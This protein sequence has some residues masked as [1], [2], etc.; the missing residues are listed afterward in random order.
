MGQRLDNID[1]LTLEIRERNVKLGWR[2]GRNTFGDYAAL[3]H[4]EVSEMVEACRDYGTTDATGLIGGVRLLP[5]KPEGVG[6]EAADVAIRLIDWADVFDL[7]G[8]LTPTGTKAPL[9]RIPPVTFGD[10]CSLLHRRISGA[11]G[12]FHNIEDGMV[13]VALNT[14][15]GTLLDFCDNFGIDL[16]AEV[17]RK[18]A[19]NATRPYRHGRGMLADRTGLGELGGTGAR[20]GDRVDRNE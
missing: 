4:S 7:T 17:A 14:I 20:T 6:S 3:L 18:N 15:L 12:I 8:R 16:N 19:Y 2:D 1:A 13:G 5:A 9:P 10:W 11:D